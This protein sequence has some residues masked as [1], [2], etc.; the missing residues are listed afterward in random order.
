MASRP[1]RCFTSDCA[2]WR[3]LPTSGR[4]PSALASNPAPA[5]NKRAAHS[6]TCRALRFMRTLLVEEL[7]GPEEADLGHAEALRRRHHVRD[8]LV[9]DQLVR[10]E[11][12]FGLHRLGGRG[13]E[14]GV[15]RCRGARGRVPGAR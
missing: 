12:E 4:T 5:P 8:V 6:T 9:G 14:A 10:T 13:A 1:L 2:A 3:G 15:P 11:V 7:L